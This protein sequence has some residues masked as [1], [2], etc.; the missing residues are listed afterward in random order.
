MGSCEGRLEVELDVISHWDRRW[1]VLR[2]VFILLV[3][4]AGLR[5]LV[6][7]HDC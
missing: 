5:T 3:M 4:V 7:V 2:I 1:Q 6:R